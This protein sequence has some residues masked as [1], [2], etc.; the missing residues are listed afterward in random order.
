M[1]E[2][3]IVIAN[4][5]IRFVYSDDLAELLDEGTA[6][7]CRASHVEPHPTKV[8]WLADM[9]P[10]GGPV[11]GANGTTHTPID[12]AAGI[13]LHHPITAFGPVQTNILGSTIEPFKTR[14]EALAAE[15]AWLTANK[16]L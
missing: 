8:G 5:H 4:G 12:M 1:A 15:R 3:T 7:V 14:A 11:L 10:S 16:G 13:D 2:H 6:A 9:R